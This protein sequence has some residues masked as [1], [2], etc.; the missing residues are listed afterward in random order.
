MS[1]KQPPEF[2]VSVLRIFVNPSVSKSS[3]V[4][5]DGTVLVTCIPKRL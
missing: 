1:A 4:C 5:N 3:K 2:Y